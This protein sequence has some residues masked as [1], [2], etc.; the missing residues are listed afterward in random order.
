MTN[1][2]IKLSQIGTFT[3]GGML[4][5]VNLLSKAACKHFSISKVNNL[6]WLVHG[7]QLY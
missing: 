2:S 7:G 4:S 3:E 5:T 6:N 1:L